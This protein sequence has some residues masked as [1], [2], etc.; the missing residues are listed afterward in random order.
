MKLWFRFLVV[1]A[2]ALAV[3]P[4][5]AAPA[6][7][8][9]HEMYQSEISAARRDGISVS[10]A[11]LYRG[12]RPLSTNAAGVY[13]QIGEYLNRTGHK[14]SEAAAL[15]AVT[16]RDPNAADWSTARRFLSDN[17]SLVALVHRAASMSYIADRHDNVD[18]PLDITFPLLASMR[19]S[20]RIVTIESLVLA[21]AGRSVDA[22]RNQSLNFRI[23][24][25]GVHDILVISWLVATAI[26]V[27]NMAGMQDIL[28]RSNGDPQ[29]AAAIDRSIREHWRP[30]SLVGPFKSEC[31]LSCSLIEYLRRIGPAA[32]YNLSSDSK[33][34][35][36][37]NLPPNLLQKSIWDTFLDTNGTAILRGMRP[38]IHVSDMPYNW[39][40]PIVDPMRL[41]GNDKGMS[42]TYA[43]SLLAV[44]ADVVPRR[45]IIGAKAA[46]TRAA[47]AV[48]VYKSKHGQYPP[49]LTDADKADL[50]PFDGKALRYRLEGNGFVIYSVGPTGKYD[51][52]V[53]DGKGHEEVFRYP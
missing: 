53:V 26:D 9:A 22:I 20:A 11:D 35:R 19:R 6:V 31:A 52:G 2:V 32:A 23:A 45:A 17:Q 10:V 48:F 4:A 29:V 43:A 27:I 13:R 12:Y 39:S 25:Q 36:V 51:G 37:P 8:T 16:K 44:M 46:I 5:K 40:K 24:D 30:R 28:I 15:Y 21:H 41:G 34:E 50:D 33:T 7:G 38:V 49:T 14:D 42:Y 18:N 3:C 1:A 47:C